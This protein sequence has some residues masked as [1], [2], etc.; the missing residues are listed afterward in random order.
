MAMRN[1][2]IL[3]IG[4][5]S[6][7]CF[8]RMKDASVH[9]A[10]NNANCELCMKFA[11][12]IPYESAD[13]IY[14]TG[15]ASNA[16]ISASLL[17]L[18]TSIVTQIGDDIHG[19]ECIRVMKRSGINRSY[20]EYLKGEKTRYHYV[21]LYEGERTI[22]V[23]HSDIVHR[24]PK[25]KHH[26][27]WI[28]LSSLPEDEDYQNQIIAYLD[29]HKEIN[30][31]FQPGTSQI[32]QGITSSINLYKRAEII[33]VNREEAKLILNI[34]D[35]SDIKSILSGLR[36]LGPKLV[37]VTDGPKGAYI[38]NGANND[39]VYFISAFPNIKPVIDRT[40]CGDAFTST[41][42]SAII[43][44][45]EITEALKWA[46]VN[47]ASVAEYLGPH[48]G[49]LSKEEIE[50]RIAKNPEIFPKTI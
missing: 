20:I 5:M 2:D 32:K 37:L 7:D 29:S 27:K 45:K 1:L 36:K 13:E 9:C 39:E 19:K 18:K 21:L 43:S 23:K 47:S 42:L 25:I 3:S 22:L 50:N 26:P 14:A 6:I 30:L 10:M 44:G 31:L 24:L 41:F 12:K 48:A 28:Y 17:G 35:D 49:L 40:G 15:N 4:N 11:S 46:S 34:T 38:M 16:V 8:I 33:S